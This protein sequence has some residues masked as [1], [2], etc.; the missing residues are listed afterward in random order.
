MCQRKQTTSISIRV[1]PAFDSNVRHIEFLNQFFSLYISVNMSLL[2]RT[3]LKH[4]SNGLSC[5]LR[6]KFRPVSISAI[7]LNAA[8]HQQRENSSAVTKSSASSNADVSTDVRPLGE[9]VK[10]NTKT[11]SYMGVILIGVTVTGVLIFAVFR[12]LFS[13][14]SSNSVYSA[15]LT[16]CV[17]DPRIQDALGAPIKGYGEETRR[18]RR[19]HV[20]HLLVERHGEK[21]MQM[22]FYIQG[23]RNKATVQLE[24][25]L[26]SSSIAHSLP[27]FYWSMGK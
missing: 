16:I 10:E 18:R 20:A 7:K 22:Q 8:N 6:T 11:A 2:L 9:R 26:V 19:Q 27:S 3:V 12:E 15:A 25:R 1:S 13:S 21:F 17:D 24:K 5:L 4:H 23:I 14:D